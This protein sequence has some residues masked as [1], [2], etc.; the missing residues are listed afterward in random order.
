MCRSVN[1]DHICLEDRSIKADSIF[2]FFIF[3]NQSAY[4]EDVELRAFFWLISD[5][6]LIYINMGLKQPNIQHKLCW[7]GFNWIVLRISN[8]M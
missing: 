4:W 5:Q 3:L 6:Y 2:Y 7:V 8:N 1:H